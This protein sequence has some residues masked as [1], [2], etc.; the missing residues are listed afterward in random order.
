MDLDKLMS[1]NPL[2]PFIIL[3]VVSAVITYGLY[4]G[5]SVTRL[6]HDKEK[7]EEYNWN[8]FVHA[9]QH[10]PDCD[11]MSGKP[12]IN[13]ESNTAISTCDRCGLRWKT[14]LRG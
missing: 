14:K 6:G 3:L 5:V 9:T 1:I 10:C 7:H 8:K 12:N 11:M 13:Y 4:R 2:L